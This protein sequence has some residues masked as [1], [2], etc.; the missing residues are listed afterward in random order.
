[1]FHECLRWAREYM[2]ELP[3]TESILNIALKHARAHNV[4]RIVSISLRIGELSDLVNEWVQHYFDYLSKDTIAEGAKLDIERSPVVF[5]CDG[6]EKSFQV[7][8]KKIKEVICPD[9]GGK[10]NTLISGREY[11][12][13]NIAVI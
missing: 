13:K 12:I 11:Y 8:I 4:E 1:M 2:H 6:C 5:R 10:K 9:C 7:D 3:V